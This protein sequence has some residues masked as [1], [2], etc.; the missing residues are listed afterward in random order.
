ME[1][2]DFSGWLP[3][4]IYWNDRQP[5]VDWGYLGNRRFTEPF[6]SQTTDQ[7]VR[8]P[9][10]FLFRHQTPLAQLGEIAGA[11]PEL[12]PT[13]FIFHMSRCG[14][15]LI[16][17]KLAAARANV[18]L[19]E[20][21]P[22]DGV[23]RARFHDPGLGEDVIVQWLQWVV[24]AL[25]WRRHPE[26]ENVFIKFDCWHTLFLPLIQRAFPAVPWIFL[27]REP[28]EVMAS[29]LKQR[30]AQMIPGALEP[31]IFGWDSATVGQMAPNEYG[32][33]ALAKICAAALDGGQRETGKLVNYR[34]L[35]DAVWPALTRFWNVQ[36]SPDD[37]ERMAAAAQANAKNP[38]LPFT[39]DSQAKRDSVPEAVRTLTRQWLESVYQELE[40]QRLAHGF[41]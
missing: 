28:L 35:P 3:M 34:Q 38:S 27:Y 37:A 26:E 12:P 11:Q 14:S 36:V 2:R 29:H 10:D 40:S 22:I 20:P 33:G 30:G 18:V 25:S 41:V 1:T 8:H 4:R 32:A 19:S 6:F 9:A 13:G 21:A 17:Q 39:A 7:C 31:E 15:T 16:S 24:A 5:M 23:L